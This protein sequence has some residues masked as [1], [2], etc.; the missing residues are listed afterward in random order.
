VFEVGVGVGVGVVVDIECQ[1]AL[2]ADLEVGG[3]APV[4]DGDDE[5]VEVVC[6]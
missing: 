3:V 6:Q 2:R 4:A 1:V 5:L